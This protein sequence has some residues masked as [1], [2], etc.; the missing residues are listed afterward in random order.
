MT[1]YEDLLSDKEI[2]AVLTFVRNSFGNQAKAIQPALVEKVR[3]QSAA[4]KGFY[5]PSELLKKYPM[6]KN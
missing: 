2:A 3:K 5:L 1:P 6:E 4:H